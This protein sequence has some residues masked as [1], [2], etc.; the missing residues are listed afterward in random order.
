LGSSANAKAPP[1][2]SPGLPV[3]PGATKPR[4]CSWPDRLVRAVMAPVSRKLA[5]VSTAILN[6]KPRTGRRQGS[7][8]F[9]LPTGG[10]SWGFAGSARGPGGM[11]QN[12][13][14][15]CHRLTRERLPHRLDLLLRPGSKSRQAAAPARVPSN[16]T[17]RRWPACQGT[18]P[19]ARTARRHK[20][21]SFSSVCDGTRRVRATL[22]GC[23]D[24]GR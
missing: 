8:C 9:L 5:R 15:S 7:F 22:R 20:S 14:E 21:L 4:A 1:R 13:N 23:S 24:S 18:A 2:G 16:R 6:W 12:K 19:L 11:F 3:P 10:H 17:R